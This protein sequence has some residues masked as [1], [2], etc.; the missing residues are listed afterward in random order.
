MPVKGT[1][2]AWFD[3][4][5]GA[6]IFHESWQRHATRTGDGPFLAFVAWLDESRHDGIE[7]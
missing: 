3:V 1:G 4:G 2:G 5:P 6:L 7:I